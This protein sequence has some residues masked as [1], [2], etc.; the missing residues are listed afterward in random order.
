MHLF[1]PTEKAVLLLGIKDE[2]GVFRFPLQSQFAP[3]L[4][5]QVK[6]GLPINDQLMER[7]EDYLGEASL[8]QALE[9]HQQFS[10]PIELADGGKAT[11]YLGV[12]KKL[13]HFDASSW[14]A[15]SPLLRGLSSRHNR[16]VYMLALQVFAGGYEQQDTLV[17]EGEEAEALI[18]DIG[19]D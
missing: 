1:C 12:L 17:F 18:D 7:A 4:F 13:D 6:V 3:G 8:R 11:L 5:L 16:M 2:L 19:Q 15:M 9:I 14:S 10:K